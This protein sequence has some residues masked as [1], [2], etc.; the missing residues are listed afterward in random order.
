MTQLYKLQREKIFR[1]T[2]VPGKDSTQ[3]IFRAVWSGTL[4]SATKALDQWLSTE[5]CEAS[6]TT[7]WMH[8]LILV[9]DLR[10]CDKEHFLLWDML[11][12]PFSSL[13]FSKCACADPYLGYR[14]AC[15][16][17]SFLEVPTMSANGKGSGGT[18]RMR[19]PAWAFAG[20]L[21]DKYLFLMCWLSFVYKL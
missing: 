17:W 16:A 13:W 4:L 19:R 15:F 7:G 18:A 10:T 8:G 2:R 5:P 11:I 14:N 20:R 6:G 1:M 21:C 3:L 12:K 9:I